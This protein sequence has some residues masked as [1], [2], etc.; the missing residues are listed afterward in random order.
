[1]TGHGPWHDDETIFIY[2]RI[3]THPHHRTA[4][5]TLHVS[6]SLHLLPS[7]SRPLDTSGLEYVIIT[8]YSRHELS[9][10]R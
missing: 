6:L 5:R 8:T 3:Y 4:P 7:R 10:P 1:M 9:R 2:T